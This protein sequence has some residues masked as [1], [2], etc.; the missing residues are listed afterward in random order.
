ML[1][2]P[3]LMGFLSCALFRNDAIL[4]QVRLVAAQDYVGLIAVRV[5]AQL[6]EPAAYVEKRLLVCDIEQ[7]DEAHSVAKERRCQTS[8]PFYRSKFDTEISTSYSHSIE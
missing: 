1:H 3:V 2:L 8:K 7:Q 6:L 4:V 5:C